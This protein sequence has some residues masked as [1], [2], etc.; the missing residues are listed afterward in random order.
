MHTIKDKIKI[1]KSLLLLYS[2]CEPI[3]IKS[4]AVVR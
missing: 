4:T 3:K 1:I 2:R